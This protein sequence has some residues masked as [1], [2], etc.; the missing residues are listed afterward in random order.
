MSELEFNEAV[1]RVAKEDDAFSCETAANCLMA[2][3]NRQH[4]LSVHKAKARIEYRAAKQYARELNRATALDAAV[5]AAAV[6]GIAV[7]TWF[8]NS[9]GAA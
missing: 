2:Y 5:M 8:L 6:I 3:A 4:L 7:V 9:I 1:N